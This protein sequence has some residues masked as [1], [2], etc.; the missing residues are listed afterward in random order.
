[1]RTASS[2]GLQRVTVQCHF[3]NERRVIT[4]DTTQIEMI[5]RDYYEQIEQGRSA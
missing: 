2:L 1:M 5:L 3:R 4:T